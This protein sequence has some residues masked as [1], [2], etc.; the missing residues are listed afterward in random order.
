MDIGDTVIH[1]RY[2]VGVI[3]AIQTRAADGETRH[4]YVIP[5]PSISS[6]IFVPVDSAEEI[7]LRPVASIDTLNEVIKILTGEC[8]CLDVTSGP[9]C[10]G[11]EDP[12]VLASIIRRKAAEPKPRYPKAS[13]QNQIKRAK[14]LLA[15]EMSVVLGISDDRITALIDGAPQIEGKHTAASAS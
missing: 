8:E 11:W 6:T 12:L 2:G 5:K 13:E 1:P 3:D 4:Y 7:G 15:E 14:K 10:Q 9:R